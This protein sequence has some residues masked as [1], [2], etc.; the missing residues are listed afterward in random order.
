MKLKRKT[1]TKIKYSLE[2]TP[3][4][5]SKLRDILY[6]VTYLTNARGEVVKVYADDLKKYKGF[7][8]RARES[9]D[10]HLH[11]WMDESK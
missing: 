5:I 10:E 2:L 9:L 3:E 1:K 6:K 11:E 4:E 8:E 7:A